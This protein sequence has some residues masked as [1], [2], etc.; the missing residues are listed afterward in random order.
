MVPG[1]NVTVPHSSL[2]DLRK[3]HYKVVAVV[4]SGT[5]IGPGSE[6]HRTAPDDTT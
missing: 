1:V 3:S 6:L 4:R 5:T 2:Q